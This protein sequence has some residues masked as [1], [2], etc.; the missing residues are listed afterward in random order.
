MAFFAVLPL[1][2]L[3]DF[4]SNEAVSG[5]ATV[6]GADAMGYF[7]RVLYPVLIA[8]CA[9]GSLDGAAFVG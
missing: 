5:F 9:F 3:A 4:E 8:V 1:S 2:A 6:F 7:G